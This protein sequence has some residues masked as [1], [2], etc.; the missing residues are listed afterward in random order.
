M[1]IKVYC[2]VSVLCEIWMQMHAAV[3]AGVSGLE[4]LCPLSLHFPPSLLLGD[5]V[6][7]ALMVAAEHSLQVAD[8]GC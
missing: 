2:D 3:E 8:T 4:V 7:E 5:H 6:M 1:L